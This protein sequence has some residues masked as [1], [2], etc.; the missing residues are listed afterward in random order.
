MSRRRA[1]IGRTPRN[2]AKTFLTADVGNLEEFLASTSPTKEAIEVICPALWLVT[3]VDGRRFRIER[4]DAL[5]RFSTLEAF[6]L[7]LD[8]RK[9]R[10]LEAVA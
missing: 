5:D 8:A 6:Q 3:T 4:R 1:P 7:A 10:C 2:F 9:A